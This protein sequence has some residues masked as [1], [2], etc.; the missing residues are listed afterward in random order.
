VRRRAGNRPRPDRGRLAGDEP[1]TPLDA[2]GTEWRT[3]L[4]DDNGMACE[5]LCLAD[6]DG[7]GRPDLVAAGRGT[8]NLKVY[9][10]ET[11]R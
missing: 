5:D 8:H 1:A 3:T 2:A 4:V 7:D 6:L 10:N 11:P 9:F